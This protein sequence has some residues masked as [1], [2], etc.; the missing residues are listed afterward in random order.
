MLGSQSV[1]GATTTIVGELP[2]GT[3]NIGDVDVASQIPG[4]GATNLGKAEDAAHATGHTGVM[5]LAVRQD[6]LAVLAA[7]GDYIPVVTDAQG[8][9]RIAALPANSGTDIGDVDVTSVVPGVAAANLGKQEDELH[10]TGDVGVMLLGVRNDTR[11]SF[12][13][14]DTDYV[15]LSIDD[16]GRTLVVVS[17]NQITITQTPTITAGAYTS[18]DALGG[19]LTFGGA[20]I[21]ASGS[22]IIQKVVITDDDNELQ[23]IDLVLFNQTFGA[24]ADNAAFA[25]SDADLQ[26]CIGHISVAATNYSS[27]DDNA[28]ATKRN[29]GFPFTAVGTGLFGQ[30]VIRDVGGYAATDDI[31]IKITIL[32]D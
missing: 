22:G 19:L 7:D 2:A 9:L 25:P 14:A 11:A 4:V 17:G 27:F 30:M 1:G 29:V 13:N 5:A 3:Q 6:A 10:A 8:R 28:V 32:M 15:P 24:T 31:T 18:G 26:N 16:E 23:P 12:G 20:T 21:L